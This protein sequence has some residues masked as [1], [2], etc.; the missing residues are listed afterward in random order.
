MIDYED[1][2]MHIGVLRKSGRYP[3]GSGENPNQRYKTFIDHINTL[4]KEGLTEKQ[5]AEGL[6]ISTTELRAMKSI[7]KTAQRQQTATAAFRLSEKG[8]SNVAIAKKLGI[9]DTQVGSLLRSYQKISDDK[10]Q[11]TANM[12]KEQV[13]KKKYLDIGEGT[14]NYLGVSKTSLNTSV[15]IL[16]DEGYQ[17]GTVKIPQAGTGELTTYKILFGPDTTYRD[18]V[19]NKALIQTIEQPDIHSNDGGRS[20]LGLRPPQNVSSK[21]LMV[22]YGEDGGAQK[23]GIIELRPGVKDLSMGNSR[24]AQV[25]IAVD[26]THYIK[27][28]AVYADNLPDGIDIRFNT[29]KP[30]GDDK[31]A[32]L[33]KMKVGEDGLIDSENPFGA[34]IKPGGQK[35][36][37][38]ILNEE[39]DWHEWAGKISSQVLSKQPNSLARSQLD[40]TYSIKKNEY[41]EIMKLSNP[42]VK[43][44]L[45]EKFADDVNASAVHLKAVGLPRTKSHVIISF[46]GIKENEVY[47]PGYENG[48][49][50]V[51]IRHPHGGIFEIP[52]LTVNNKYKEAI[53]T[54]GRPNDAIGINPKVAERLS[55]ADF[56]GDTVLVIPNKKGLIKTSPALKDLKDFDP[57]TTYKGYE[58][59]KTMTTT[60]REMGKISNLIT[61]MTIKGANFSEIARAVKHS[62]VVI[63]AEKHGLNYKQS[64]I[65]NGILELTKRYQP[66]GG[67]STLI[68]RARNTER[69]DFRKP[70]SAAEGGPID[71]KTGRKVYSAPTGETYVN[72]KGETVKRIIKTTKM[73]EALDARDLISAPGKEIEFIYADHANRLK[74]L[75]NEARKS[76]Y[77][78]PNLKYSPTARTTY[79]KEVSELNSKLNIAYKNKPLERQAQLLANVIVTAK[80]QAN[81]AM[82]KEELKKIKG[83]ALVE[84]R[85]RTGA[86]KKRIVINDTEWEAI[87]S[88]AISNNKLEQIL[89]NADIDRVKELATPRSALGMTPAKAALAKR[90][91]EA[92]YTQ[93]EV[94]AAL[95]VSVSTI[96]SLTA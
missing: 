81:P 83:Q 14:E 52:E 18:V 45:L 24:Y 55:G 12:L 76:A 2:L 72:K 66:E 92:G 16:K 59:M 41:D 36:A 25:R 84:A 49:S 46:P 28:M 29:N 90:K 65:D 86:G 82:T 60:Q 37:L 22:N 78:T 61:D 94:A 35:G 8:Y 80:R 20:F 4:R 63:D 53:K 54:I 31:L 77:T 17:V 1:E 91:L 30:K 87:Q 27:G 39:G 9:G 51:L 50:V 57:R 42:T 68:S 32:Y 3:W 40:L 34:V 73:A 74:S 64:A 21:R 56:D 62:M 96:N 13:A 48:E 43:K 15:A 10:V 33:K 95:G 93:A 11:N 69:I 58:G 85:R 44:L 89:N 79:A 47:A 7:A 75:A 71:I 23:D 38:N 19:K 70:R 26:G 67:A 5:I 6:A 88:G